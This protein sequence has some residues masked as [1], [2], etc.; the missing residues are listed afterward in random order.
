MAKTTETGNLASAADLPTKLF[1][2]AHAWEQWLD[3]NHG[4]SR[5]VWKR[6]AEFVR[7][8]A[9]HETLHPRPRR[10]SK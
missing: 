6:I 5:G 10:T 7:M 9:R 3:T 2:T 4:R 1:P 8:L